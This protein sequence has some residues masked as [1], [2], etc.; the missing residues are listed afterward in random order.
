MDDK[1]NEERQREWLQL[2]QDSGH[3]GSILGSLWDIWGTFD[4]A[5]GL[6]DG[7]LPH[8]KVSLIADEQ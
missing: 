6:G 8:I 1:S 5:A 7:G 2:I 4:G 3:F